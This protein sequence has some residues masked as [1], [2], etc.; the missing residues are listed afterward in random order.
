MIHTRVELK[1]SL[2]VAI[3]KLGGELFVDDRDEVF[4]YADDENRRLVFQRDEQRRGVVIW[5]EE[6][7][8]EEWKK[9]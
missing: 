9:I 5:V 1:K 6:K 7:V 4:N 3:R 8:G 2:S